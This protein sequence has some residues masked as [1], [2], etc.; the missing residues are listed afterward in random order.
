L[1]LIVRIADNRLDRGLEL[2]QLGLW[3][4]ALELLKPELAEGQR[5]EPH[6][7]HLYS[8]PL[9]AT[10]GIA[11]YREVY[12]KVLRWMGDN[13]AANT[14]LN[15][16]H[17]CALAPI[18]STDVARLVQLVDEG[19]AGVKGSSWAVEIQ[20]RVQFRAGRYQEVLDRNETGGMGR[21]AL[22][23]L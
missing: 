18:P 2:A 14:K 23:A 7:W 22:R 4:E 13:P 17:V 9:L 3:P 8:G 16:S 6:V 5:L 12:G 19:V 10:G 11:A 15:V 1:S 21:S 20:S